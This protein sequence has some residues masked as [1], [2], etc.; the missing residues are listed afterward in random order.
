M[1]S[2]RDGIQ[3]K[4][5]ALLALL[6]IDKK[7]GVQQPQTP[8]MLSCK[9]QINR[10]DKRIEL[11]YQPFKTVNAEV[12]NFISTVR[13]ALDYIPAGSSPLQNFRSEISRLQLFGMM[14]MPFV[15]PMNVTH[16]ELL[17]LRHGLAEFLE[18]EVPKDRTTA[19][20]KIV[21]QLQT[22]LGC[23]SREALAKRLGTNDSSIRAAIREDQAHSGPVAKAKILAACKEHGVDTR[24]WS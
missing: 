14:A 11:A 10:L 2:R 20:K 16:S 23:E 15:L 7:T 3:G 17:K 5:N 13:D 8:E 24:H 9:S 4:Y 19:R 22:V 1:S 6:P 21:N 12:R 18:S